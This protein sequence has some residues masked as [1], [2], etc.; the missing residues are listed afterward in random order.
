MEKKTITSR[1]RVLVIKPENTSPF[2][3]QII[4]LV[5]SVGLTTGGGTMGS[6]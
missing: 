1:R 6:N 3:K 2:L 4:D 5:N